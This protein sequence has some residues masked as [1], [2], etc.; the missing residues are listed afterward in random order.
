MV[1]DD[2]VCPVC[3]RWLGT[4]IVCGECSGARRWFVRGIYGFYYEGKLREAIHAFKFSGAKKVGRRLVR[5]VEDRIRALSGGF[6]CVVPVPVSEKRLKERGFNQSFI[7]SNEIKDITG[8]DL[9]HHALVKRAPTKDQ[10]S[11]SRRER[12]RNIRG[13]FQVRDTS[14]VADRRILLVDDL[15]TT[16]YTAGEA[17]R[18]LK[19]AGC[20]DVALFAL[21]RTP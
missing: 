6:D 14:C 13:A 9:V 11:L 8:I 17:A 12:A 19:T 21:A 2:A 5:I 15:F 4:R 10:F 1:E 16:G 20:R 18:T 3:G 7:I